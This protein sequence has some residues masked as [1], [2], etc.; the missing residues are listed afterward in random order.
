MVDHINN[1]HTD[2]R[3]EN[4]QLITQSE[5][6]KKVNRKGKNLPPIRVRAIN[7]NSGE[8]SDYDSIKKCS[9]ELHIEN[10]SIRKILEGIYKTSTSKKDKNK[11]KFEK[12]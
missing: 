8:S 3:L 7:I 1:I 10:A 4:L 2:N 6:M 5:N 9:K 12:I 11:Y